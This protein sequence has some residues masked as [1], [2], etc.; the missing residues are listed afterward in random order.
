MHRHALSILVVAAAL[1]GCNQSPAQSSDKP[2]GEVAA[3]QAASKPSIVDPGEQSVPFVMTVKG[4]DALPES[5]EIE[6]AV[7]ITAQKEFRVPGTL[8]VLLPTSA[9]L[10][11]GNETESLA[12]IPAGETTRV[13][14]VSL[15]G[16]LG[17]GQ[18]IKVVLDARAPN[19]AY[20]A[21][22]EQMYPEIQQPQATKPSSRVPPPP[23]SRPIGMP[24]TK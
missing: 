1:V 11:S 6:L 24:P 16:K 14:R 20:G 4:P 7:K 19:A 21:H 17:V 13:Y 12:S 3:E 9:K 18:Q 10:V 22:S 15:G 2:A 23:I 5:G 8:K